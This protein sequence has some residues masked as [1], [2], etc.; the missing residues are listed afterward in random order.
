MLVMFIISRIVK[1]GR[2]YH[3]KPDARRYTQLKLEQAVSELNSGRS[4]RYVCKKYKIPRGTLQ[5]KLAKRHGKKQKPGHP[6][7]YC[8]N[9]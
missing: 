5:N 7:V 3:R 1:M 8:N 2:T 6:T 9:R 4:Q